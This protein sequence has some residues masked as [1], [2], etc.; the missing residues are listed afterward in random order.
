MITASYGYPVSVVASHDS[1]VPYHQNHRITDIDTRG[2]VAMSG[3]F[4]Y[5]LDLTKLSQEEKDKIKNQII[6]FKADRDIIHNGDYYRVTPGGEN[7]EYAA[8][9]MVSAE[10]CHSH[11]AWEAQGSG[12][13]YHVSLRRN[14]RRLLA[15][16]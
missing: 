11:Y 1:A 15:Q 13:E 4:G 7:R 14:R 8:R 3:N 16:E 12:A 6:R 5:E 9:N 10:S 2:V